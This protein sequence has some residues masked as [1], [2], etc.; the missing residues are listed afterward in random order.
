MPK[1]TTLPPETVDAILRIID[2]GMAAEVKRERDTLVVVEISRKV[3]N[4][5]DA[6]G[7]A[8]CEIRL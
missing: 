5:T 8:A 1:V 6:E 3:R 4:K 7:C 2:G